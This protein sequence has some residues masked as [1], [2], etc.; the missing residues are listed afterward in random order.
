MTFKWA[1]VLNSS[2]VNQYYIGMFDSKEEAWAWINKRDPFR[3]QSY[4][5]IKI[6]E[7]EEVN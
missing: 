3:Q 4:H 2:S 7:K 5:T 1:V 6:Q